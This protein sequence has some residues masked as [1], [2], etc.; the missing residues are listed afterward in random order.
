MLDGDPTICGLSLTGEATAPEATEWT[1][2]GDPSPPGVLASGDT[3]ALYVEASSNCEA[4]FNGEQHPWPILEIGLPSGGQVRATIDIDSTCGV[5][6][7]RCG[8]PPNLPPTEVPYTPSPL[9]ASIVAPPIV[10]I[11]D[12]LVYTVTLA[13]PIAITYRFDPCP[14]YAEYLTTFTG[15]APNQAF[16]TIN[17]YRLNCAV[18][19]VAAH[20]SVSYEMR[21]HVPPDQPLGDARFGW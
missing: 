4:V 3:A 6:V 16:P 7:S 20:S 9:T 19:G 21:L 11:G 13:K 10:R 14:V 15:E 5:G 1:F 12:V 18:E 2:F 17:Y 8:I